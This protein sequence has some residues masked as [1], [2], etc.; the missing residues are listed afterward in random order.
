MTTPDSFVGAYRG[1]WHSYFVTN[2]RIC[3]SGTS[4]NVVKTRRPDSLHGVLSAAIER[5][6]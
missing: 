2:D 6:F 3:H 1:T 4:K 5:N